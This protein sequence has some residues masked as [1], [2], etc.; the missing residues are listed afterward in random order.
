LISKQ[1]ISSEGRNNK[2]Y[3][4]EREQKEQQELGTLSLYEYF[5][6]SCEC[7]WFRSSSM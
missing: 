5:F 7:V 6:N 3:I 2:V 4:K 1:R